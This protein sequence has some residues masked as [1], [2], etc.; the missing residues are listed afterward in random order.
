ML[1]SPLMVPVL[2]VLLLSIVGGDA[3]PPRLSHEP[4]IAI[5]VGGPRTVTAEG[6]IYE[7]DRSAS[8]VVCVCVC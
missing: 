2:V 6:L 5:N 1:L 7:A 4:L 8:S 3:P